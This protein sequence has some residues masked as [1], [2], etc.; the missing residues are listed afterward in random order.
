M[1][2]S[3]IVIS[4]IGFGFD[5]LVNCT[6]VYFDKSTSHVVQPFSSATDVVICNVYLTAKER[7]LI[8]PVKTKI[9]L[10]EEPL[11]PNTWFRGAYQLY[12]SGFFDIV[13]GCIHDSPKTV[14]RPFYLKH[15]PFN[16]AN[17]AVFPAVNARVASTTRDQLRSKTLGALINRHDPG[18]TRVPLYSVLSAFGRV[19][20][21]G[22]LLNNTS[23]KHLNQV[24]KPKW[25]EN[26]LFNICPEN[27]PTATEGYI[28]EKLFDTLRGGAIPI[29][30]GKLTALEKKLF[31]TDRILQV[32]PYDK[33]SLQALYKQLKEWL[34]EPTLDKLLTFYQQPVFHDHAYEMAQEVMLQAI[35]RFKELVTAL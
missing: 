17:A 21:P 3:P 28:S 30:F 7:V 18:H 26:I 10:V 22:K 29:Y 34:Q 16:A 24:G 1:A 15:F 27:F 14:Y 32:N 31:N 9:L 25:L 20:C 6:S 11:G 33:R 23:N 2:A 4:F 13:Y 12:M 5:P 19:L 8:Q 35:A